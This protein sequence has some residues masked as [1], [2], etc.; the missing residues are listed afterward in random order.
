MSKSTAVLPVATPAV[1]REAFRAGKFTASDKALPSLVGA[2]G[3]GVVR[4][5]I[6]PVA[7]A[8][9][10]DQVKGYSAPVLSN[11][12]SN[13]VKAPALVTVPRFNAKGKALAPT[14]LTRAEVLTLAGKPT[15]TKGR[16]S[17]E[18]IAAAGAAHVASGA[19]VKKG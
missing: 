4:G 18:T 19:K 17:K 11:G 1:I 8:E 3:N 14:V 6:S 7:V 13:T 16:L 15:N 5:R 2:K 9:F 10:M 12:V